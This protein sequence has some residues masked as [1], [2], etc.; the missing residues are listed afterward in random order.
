MR[1]KTDSWKWEPRV[2]GLVSNGFVPSW[3]TMSAWTRWEDLD[4]AGHMVCWSR[5]TWLMS[6]E[7]VDFNA[8]LMDLTQPVP[9]NA[10][11]RDAILVQRQEPA[12][13]K[14]FGKDAGE[15]DAA[16]REFVTKNYARK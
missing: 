1:E 10:G 8:Y 5:V 3:K 4:A 11:D 15:M 16:W 13:K 2:F 6:L 12:L 7:G 14:A 9:S